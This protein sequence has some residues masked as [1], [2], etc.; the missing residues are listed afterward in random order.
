M[1]ES[2]VQTTPVSDGPATPPGAIPPAA[3]PPAV[4]ARRRSPLHRLAAELEAGSSEQV[5]LSEHPFLA[6]IGVRGRP[7]G[8]AA[9]A[10]EAELGG[11]LP[12]RAGDV[13]QLSDETHVLWLGPDEFLVVAP[14]E[15][16]GGPAPAALVARLKASLDG[17][18]GEVMQVVDLSANRT[19]LELAGPRAQEVLDRSVRIDL[20][21]VALP[22]GGAVVTLLAGIGVILW[23]TADD[24]FRVMPRSSFGEHTARWLLDGM[25]EFL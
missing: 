12:A 1:A 25:R 6:Q 13:T 8:A 22:T 17:I 2:T 24:V 7:G 5:R 23:R 20:D 9:A 21:P 18:T 19:T 16:Q 15:A 11:P 10:V 3:T 4:L 14:D